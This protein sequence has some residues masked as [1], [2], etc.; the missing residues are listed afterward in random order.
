[1]PGGDEQADLDGRATAYLAE[2]EGGG[3]SLWQCFLFIWLPLKDRQVPHPP[4]SPVHPPSGF[5][6]LKIA[7]EETTLLL[8]YTQTKWSGNCTRKPPHLLALSSA[9]DRIYYNVHP[10]PC[11]CQAACGVTNG[12]GESLVSQGGGDCLC[13]SSHR[14]SKPTHYTAQIGRIQ[15]HSAWGRGAGKTLSLMVGQVAYCPHQGLHH[16]T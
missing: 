1:M 16:L 9:V 5:I 10:A 2:E 4:P 14:T 7:Q 6:C 15:N 13:N 12:W 8:L 3:L 11:L